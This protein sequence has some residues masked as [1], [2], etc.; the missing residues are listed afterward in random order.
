MDLRITVGTCVSPSNDPEVL[1]FKKYEFQ[2]KFKDFER[3]KIRPSDRNNSAEGSIPPDTGGASGGIDLQSSRQTR[4]V[5]LHETLNRVRV[6]DRKFHYSW[7][8]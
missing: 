4:V 2:P 8:G 5:H 7:R 6:R 3:I 1:L